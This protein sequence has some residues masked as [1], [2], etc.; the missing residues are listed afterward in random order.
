MEE[1]AALVI[2][3]TVIFGKLW[4]PGDLR[5]L[6]TDVSDQAK[7]LDLA[8]TSC[9]TVSAAQ[10]AAWRSTMTKVADFVGTDFGWLTTTLPD[11]SWSFWGGDKSVADRGQ[12]LTRELY[13]QGQMLEGQKCTLAAPNL[14]PD[15]DSKKTERNLDRFASIVKYGGVAAAFLG[16]AYV[17]GKV[18]EL[19]P[20]PAP[21]AAKS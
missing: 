2:L 20:K 17:V 8:I 11:G 10:L 14:D 5:R 15:A 21:R 12:E 6:Q 9:P 1:L 19:I 7:K 18:V 4:S 16:T 3:A 13:A